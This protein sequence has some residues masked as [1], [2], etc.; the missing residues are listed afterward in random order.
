MWT[1]RSAA[2]MDEPQFEAA[3]RK[4]AQAK[5][6]PLRRGEQERKPGWRISLQGTARSRALWTAELTSRTPRV[7]IEAGT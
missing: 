3:L 1:P 5:P 6:Q 7:Q 2:D 4:V